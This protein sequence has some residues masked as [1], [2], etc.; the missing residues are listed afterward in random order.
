MI[1]DILKEFR[2]GGHTKGHTCIL[3]APIFGDKRQIW[4]GICSNRYV[5][6]PSLNVDLRKPFK[7]LQEVKGTLDVGDGVCGLNYLCIEC[8]EVD[9]HPKL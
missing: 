1:H 8:T 3:P 2:C 7:W 5:V 9:T 4:V 6:E